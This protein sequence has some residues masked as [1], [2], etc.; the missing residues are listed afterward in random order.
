VHYRIRESTSRYDATSV[1]EVIDP[2]RREGSVLGARRDDFKIA[3]V[4]EGGAIRGVL[5]PAAVFLAS[6]DARSLTGVTIV[7]D[8]ASLTR[9]YPR[10]AEEFEKP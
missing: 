5:S 8:G 9:G 10:S 6:D 2:R 3:L 4:T 7:S 1:L